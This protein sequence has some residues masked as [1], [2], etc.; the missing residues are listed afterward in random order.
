MAQ[1]NMLIWD[2]EA[3]EEQLD[4]LETCTPIVKIKLFDKEPIEIHRCEADGG[5]VTCSQKSLSSHSGHKLRQPV[6]ITRKE[7]ELL[8]KGIIK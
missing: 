4:E 6:L 1:S 2:G 7:I 8:E 5:L 3:T